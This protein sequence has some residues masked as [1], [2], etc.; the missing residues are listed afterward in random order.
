MSL[1]HHVLLEFLASRYPDERNARA[2]L[3]ALAL[4]PP[5][6]DSYRRIRQGVI[7]KAPTVVR[8]FLNGGATQS[9]DPLWS[10]AHRQRF[11]AL[12]AREMAF[13]DR[14]FPERNEFEAAWD[15]M[16]IEAHRN[17]LDALLV[18]DARAR[19]TKTAEIFDVM[20]A[21]F[22]VGISQPVL[23]LYVRYF[24]NMKWVSKG[25]WVHYLQ[26]C[27]VTRR[28]MLLLAHRIDDSSRLR[29]RLGAAPRF[30]YP[31][32]LADVLAEAYY[33]FKDHA[34]DQSPTKAVAWSKVLMNAGDRREKYKNQDIKDLRS[35][36]QLEFE[37]LEQEFPSLEDVE[38]GRLDA[39][40]AAA[41]RG[42]IPE[43]E[44][45]K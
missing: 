16:A 44:P 20:K 18:Q 15:L 24:F 13:S 30:S 22:D 42:E 19:G 32:V 38:S 11:G 26:E 40:I 43:F 41:G 12:W 37:Y 35:D 1:P 31:N 3:D 21:R 25:E 33:K 9:L 39:A 28:E 8:R 23:D 14:T 4:P 17:V 10:W 5:M 6:P 2:V 45:R 34:D 27:S 36:L 7:G 29:H